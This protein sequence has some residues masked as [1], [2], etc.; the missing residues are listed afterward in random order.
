MR[1]PVEIEY[2]LEDLSNEGGRLGRHKEHDVRS[3]AYSTAEAPEHVTMETTF[4]ARRSVILDQGNVGS[5][6]GNAEAGVIATDSLHRKGST[7]IDEH[8]ALRLYQNATR[9]DHIQG[10]YPPDDTGSTGL[11][12]M[13]AAKKLG[14]IS[15]YR[16][17]FSFRATLTALQAGPAI[18]G[19]AWL[20]GCDTPDESGI[21][22]YKGSIRGGHEVLC[23]GVDMGVELLWF[24]NS[25]GQDWGLNGSFAM[26][27]E[28]FKVA[29]ADGGDVTVPTWI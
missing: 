3:F 4:W 23:R 1:I 9:L 14:W 29:M 28:D 22:D 11:A 8:V 17:S 19:M 26:R 5:C 15:G 27:F 2:L 24:D 12:V 25:W 6:T 7:G 20:T 13:K 10:E 21:I 16:H 18:V